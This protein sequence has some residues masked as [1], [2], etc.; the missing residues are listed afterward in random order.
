MGELSNTTING[1]SY[2]FKDAGA[3]R[4]SHSHTK[5]QI[6]DFPTSM[7]ASDVSTWAKESKKPTYTAS[8]V[9][10]IATTEKGAANGVASLDSTGKVPSSQLPS[11]VDDVLEY[12]AKSSFPAT[13]ESGKIY[14]DT[15]NNKTYRW[16]W[17]NTI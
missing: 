12:S 11:Y 1:V 9:G 8:E 13:G 17:R 5:S 10:A 2:D 7:P 14:V 3:A 16:R 4:Q 15:S 6:T